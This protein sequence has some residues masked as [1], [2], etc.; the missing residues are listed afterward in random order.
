MTTVRYAL[1]LVLST[2]ALSP[3]LGEAASYDVWSCNL[4]NG[5]NLPVEGWVA[6]KRGAKS[7]ART[8][9]PT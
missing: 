7:H 4:P 2:I 6:E 5:S 1:P 9:V 8:A 3:A